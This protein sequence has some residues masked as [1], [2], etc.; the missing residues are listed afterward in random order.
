MQTW[1]YATRSRK[2]IS[3]LTSIYNDEE[4]VLRFLNA[5]CSQTVPR[6]FNVEFLICNDR[7]TDETEKIIK[8][9]EKAPDNDQF[10]IKKI[11]NDT[12]RGI[13]YSLNRLYAL[14]NGDIIV[15]VDA[16]A[17]PV[18]HNWLE[19]LVRPIIEKKSTVVQGNF[20]KQ[21]DSQ[22]FLAQMHERWRRSVF[23]TRHQNS[24]GSLKTVNSR[25]L[26]IARNVLEKIRVEFGYILNPHAI[27]GA[28]TELG[29]EVVK[30]GF[31]IDLH[32]EAEVGHC[33]PL[34][35]RGL[36]KQKIWHGYNDGLIGISY[37]HS[38]YHAVLLPYKKEGVSLFFSVPVTLV[39]IVA[40]TIGLI[41]CKF[42]FNFARKKF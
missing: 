23:L 32:S 25:N 34:T 10:V 8:C 9:F 17:I 7:S 21:Y 18:G 30:A 6:S 5:V 26:A 38:F 28:D 3:I 19:N 29:F 11:D 33:D 14:S 37:P 35:F 1:S 41:Q 31:K 16:D 42:R 20:W 13:T 27:C 2:T 39:F 15:F 4:T 40:N 36:I 24:N 22:T 12:N